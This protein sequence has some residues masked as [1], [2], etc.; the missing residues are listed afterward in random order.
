M[1]LLLPFTKQDQVHHITL[2]ST[3]Q[4]V[5]QDLQEEAQLYSTLASPSSSC[6]PPNPQDMN[7]GPSRLANTIL[8]KTLV[9]VELRM[10]SCIFF[11]D[12]LPILHIQFNPTSSLNPLSHCDVSL[13]EIPLSPSLSGGLPQSHSIIIELII[14]LLTAHLYLKVPEVSNPQNTKKMSHSLTNLLLIPYSLM[15]AP[16][17]H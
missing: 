6:L 15:I 11:I 5:N 10:L 4:N 12:I 3:F 13:L 2:Y 14:Q 16:F 7:S 17:I 1:C 9:C 8:L